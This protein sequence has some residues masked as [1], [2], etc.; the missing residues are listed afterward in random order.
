MSEEKRKTK[1]IEEEYIEVSE[2]RIKYAVQEFK[3]AQPLYGIASSSFACLVSF[4]VAYIS[5]LNQ[6][7]YWKIVFL[8][9]LICSGIVLFIALGVSFYRKRI[10]RGTVKWL[11]KEI[12]NNHPFKMKKRTDIVKVKKIIFNV[13]SFL[14]IISLIIA[15]PLIYYGINNWSSN[16]SVDF[17]FWVFWC[18]GTLFLLTMGRNMLSL[19]AYTVFGYEDGFLD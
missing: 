6:E 15:A 1:E 8:I 16:G 3:K 13:V 9:L 19:F 2:S 10:G 17:V 12:E 18:L 14:I 5:F 7:S 11:M 4:F